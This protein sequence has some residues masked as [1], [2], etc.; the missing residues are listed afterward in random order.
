MNKIRYSAVVL[1]E[2]SHNEIVNRFKTIIPTGW[3]I[4][5]HHMT[6][7]L[8]ELDEKYKKYLNK[9][10]KL[11]AHDIGI[12]DM[13]VAVGVSGFFSKNKKPHITLAVN[14]KN[15]GKPVMSNYINDWMP[16]TNPI[17]LIGIVKEIE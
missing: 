11:I 12:D 13:A 2:K 7:N 5:A 17:E 15:G 10:V 1:D 9:S 3:E 6:I 16:L 14:R 4:I 8:G